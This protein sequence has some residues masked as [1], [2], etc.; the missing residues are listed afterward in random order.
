MSTGLTQSPQCDV[1][2][3]RVCS[4]C[5]CGGSERMNDALMSELADKN[6]KVRKEGLDKV[7]A[8]VNEVKF[9]TSNIGP[10]P[11][12]LK[13]RLTDSNKILVCIVTSQ[14]YAE[15]CCIPV[16]CHLSVC[17]VG[18]LRSQIGILQK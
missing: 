14:C 15:R 1:T 3:L 2:V 16:I 8:I 10:L 18:G 12:A 4:V 6:W 9:I 11:E 5:V 17:N 13:P 7:V